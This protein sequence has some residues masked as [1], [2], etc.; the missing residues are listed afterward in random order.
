MK[1]DV[2]LIETAGRHLIWNEN[3][4]FWSWSEWI[5]LSCDLNRSWIT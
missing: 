3:S 2:G 1:V 5:L 4:I